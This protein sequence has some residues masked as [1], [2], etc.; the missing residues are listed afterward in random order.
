MTDD[1]INRLQ[2]SI[3]DLLNSNLFNSFKKLIQELDE[4]SDSFHI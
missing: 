4:T 2:A 1:D 3:Q